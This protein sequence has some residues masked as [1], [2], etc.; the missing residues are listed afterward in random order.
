MSEN[1]IDDGELQ[2]IEE[3]IPADRKHLSFGGSGETIIDVMDRA[4]RDAHERR[5][6]EDGDYA[7]CPL[8][9]VNAE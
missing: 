8:C 6:H 2:Q 5:L 7:G 4:D 3:S 9:E 1:D